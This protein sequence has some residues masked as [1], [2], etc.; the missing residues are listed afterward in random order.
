MKARVRCAWPKNDLAVAYHDTEWG[1]PAHDDRVL[2]EFLVLEGAQAGLSWDTILRKRERYRTLFA[3]FEP[4]AVARFSEGRCERIL[5]DPGIVRNRAKVFSAVTNA[6]ALLAVR[7]EFGSFDGYVWR[8]V[9][10]RPIVAR[11][12]T[13]G[14]VPSSTPVSDALSKDLRRRGFAFVGTTICYSFMQ[15]VGM[16]NDHLESCFRRRP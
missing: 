16:V 8:F 1:V 4:A 14:D 13:P 2:F 5:R 10:G 15:A 6:R 12:R 3:G 7:E 9:D 11:R